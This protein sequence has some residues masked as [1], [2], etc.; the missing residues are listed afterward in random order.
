MKTLAIC[1]FIFLISCSKTPTVAGGGDDFPSMITLCGEEVASV[2]NGVHTE[3]DVD[4]VSHSVL[5]LTPPT[6]KRS[7]E[8]S[9]DTIFVDTVRLDHGFSVIERY[10]FDKSD[11]KKIFWINRTVNDPAGT[12]VLKLRD[13]DGDGYLSQPGASPLTI[14]ITASGARSGIWWYRGISL[15]DLKLKRY[16]T[17]LPLRTISWYKPSGDSLAS[18]GDTVT[19]FILKARDTITA[20]MISVGDPVKLGNDSLLSIHRNSFRHGTAISLDFLPAL[21]Q[22]YR[23]RCGSGT[24]TGTFTRNDSTLVIHGFYNENGIVAVNE[25]GDTIQFSRTGIFI[26]RGTL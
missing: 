19:V 13:A 23:D 12:Y 6:L 8:L 18:E 9:G 10:A 21:P 17:E 26:K 15:S 11:L 5:P 3:K 1:L 25:S 4:S 24:V 7:M 2:I 20:K 16:T 22:T 14:T